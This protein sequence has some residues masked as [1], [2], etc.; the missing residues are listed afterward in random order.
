[1][2]SP[3]L[4]VDPSQLML[5]SPEDHSPEAVEARLWRCLIEQGYF[6]EDTAL[7][8]K[9][10]AVPELESAPSPTITPAPEAPPAPA[11]ED[12]FVDLPNPASVE[13]FFA[14]FPNAA[15][16]EGFFVDLP[17][18][19]PLE[20][21]FVDLPDPAPLEVFSNPAPMANDF[22]VNVSNPHPSPLPDSGQPKIYLWDGRNYSHPVVLAALL[23]AVNG[24]AY[25][26]DGKLYSIYDL[27]N[28]LQAFQTALTLSQSFD[29]GMSGTWVTC[30]TVPQQQLQ[31]KLPTTPKSLSRRSSGDG[32]IVDDRDAWAWVVPT[33]TMKTAVAGKTAGG[34]GGP[35]LGYMTP[36]SV[37][38]DSTFPTAAFPLAMSAAAAP[39][40]PTPA[41]MPNLVAGVPATPAPTLT[42]ISDSV[43]GSGKKRKR[44]LDAAA[45]PPG[46][47]TFAQ[48]IVPPPEVYV[49]AYSHTRE[50]RL[51]ERGRV[52][53][54]RRYEDGK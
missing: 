9:P 20:E 21:L 49:S 37:A 51:D 22:S 35:V 19:A 3:S 27:Q 16:V 23:S 43:S 12:F 8:A 17:D 44:R 52:L 41:S 29:H 38:G 31:P 14:D 30:A 26:P 40:T 47:I 39:C 7:E 42:N 32:I 34:T 18:P 36:P 4:T 53:K 54:R 1:M 13:D 5:Q 45:G 15:P 50:Y 6:T 33:P 25:M 48:N 11:V 24:V 10:A 28:G 2:E 46:T